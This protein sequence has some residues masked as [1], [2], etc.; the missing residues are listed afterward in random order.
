MSQSEIVKDFLLAQE[1]TR[2]VLESRLPRSI[3]NQIS[4]LTLETRVK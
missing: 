1:I 4:S 2:R 3:R